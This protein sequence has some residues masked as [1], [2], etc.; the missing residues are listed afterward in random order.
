MTEYEGKLYW[1]D[2]L[3]FTPKGYDYLREII[4]QALK[5]ILN[6]LT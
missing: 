3:H 5:L 6:S 1:D 2:H 4:Y